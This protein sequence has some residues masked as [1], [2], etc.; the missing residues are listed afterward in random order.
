MM[1]FKDDNIY[2]VT[3][4]NSPFEFNKQVA[5]VFPDMIGRSVP[6]YQAVINMIEQLAGRYVKDKTNCYD[7]GCS[8]GEATL[9]MD[10]GI[11]NANTAGSDSSSPEI[12][13]VSVDNSTAM[14]DRCQLHLDCYK[15]HSFITLKCEDILTTKI[16]NASMVVLNYT[17]QFIPVEK[18]ESLINSIFEGLNDGAILIVS[19][20]ISFID[21][22]VNQL[23]IEL[24]HQFKKDNGY[25]DLEISQKRNALENVLIPETLESH[26]KRMVDAGFKHVNCWQQHLNF[27]SFIAIK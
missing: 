1:K 4:E 9:A 18:R 6:G 19:E 12:T 3:Q 13:I 27:A 10:R 16:E 5:S 24:H 23:F 20:K 11:V 21:Q 15:H 14:L 22:P 25:S 26:V 17:L 8:L 7:L 2:K